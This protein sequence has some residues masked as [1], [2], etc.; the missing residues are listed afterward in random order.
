[1]VSKH[2]PSLPPWLALNSHRS[3]ALA[4]ASGPFLTLVTLL[5]HC[6]LS[7]ELSQV[8]S[9]TDNSRTS[10]TT[11]AQSLTP[12]HCHSPVIASP[13]CSPC[14]AP[15]THGS[16]HVCSP[17]WHLLVSCPR[18]V[19]ETWTDTEEQRWQLVLTIFSASEP[20]VLCTG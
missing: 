19:V 13:L 14:P 18:T 12:S 1:M 2:S 16:D 10:H 5:A 7:S 3:P 11:V 9:C 17:S 15:M 8:Q 20:W 4:L 6:A